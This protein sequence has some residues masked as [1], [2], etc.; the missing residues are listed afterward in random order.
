MVGEDGGDVS[1]SRMGLQLRKR[2][3]K[4]R[5]SGGAFDEGADL[6]SPATVLVSG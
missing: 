1:P 4:R 3:K 2:R 5:A 6:E